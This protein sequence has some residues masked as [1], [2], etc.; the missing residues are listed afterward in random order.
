MVSDVLVLTFLKAFDY[1]SNRFVSDDIFERNQKALFIDLESVNFNDHLDELREFSRLVSRLNLVIVGLLE[2][3]SLP[4]VSSS[5]FSGFDL[6]ITCS[7]DH[8]IAVTVNDLDNAI[9]DL[10]SEIE[11][12]PYAA[13]I[14]AQLL[15]QE[16]FNDVSKGLILE[17]LTYALLQS[18]DEFKSWLSERGELS[19]PADEVPV[20]ESHRIGNTLS[21]FLN[22][23]NRANA[24]SST[25]RDALYETLQTAI[26]DK[27]IESIS[28]R[29]NG[30][31]FCSG[32][33]L[34]E[35]GSVSSPPDGHLVRLARSP[36]MSVHQ[37]CTRMTAY[38]HGTC[39]GAG[40]EIPAFASKVI[41]DETVS[42][43]LPEVSMGLIP[44][45][46]GTVSI[47]RRIGRHK[48]L[49]L[50]LSGKSIGP[51]IAF[52]WGLVDDVISPE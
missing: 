34:A 10:S 3:P 6:V 18:G 16:A 26:S 5:L 47:P 52:Q 42:I 9:R 45:A 41:V 28:L 12:N 31:S 48:T 40:I 49:Y 20:V 43:F 14:L 8:R 29:G 2:R 35:F 38:L 51:E 17:S 30:S 39:A 50:A 11:K 19:Q 1:V 25:M 7:Q 37:L 22:R 32:G 46:G 24:F 13:I 27:T 15:R 21:I 4:T 33:E 36:S 23:P 44:G